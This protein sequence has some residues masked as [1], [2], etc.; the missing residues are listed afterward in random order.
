MIFLEMESMANEHLGISGIHFFASPTLL[1]LM[2]KWTD[3]AHKE[4]NYHSDG[5]TCI[6]RVDI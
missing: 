2:T 6:I 1:Y 3:L 4:I 5:A